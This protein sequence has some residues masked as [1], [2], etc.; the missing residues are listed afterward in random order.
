M[1]VRSSNFIGDY[2]WGN[3]RSDETSGARAFYR[4]EYHDFLFCNIAMSRLP[5]SLASCYAFAR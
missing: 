1:K 4:A 2:G 3:I 5:L